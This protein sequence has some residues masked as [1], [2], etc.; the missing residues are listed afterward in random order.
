MVDP[1][2]DQLYVMSIGD[3]LSNV[4][5]AK[6]AP[7]LWRVS[8]LILPGA[9][10]RVRRQ[11][12]ASKLVVDLED[13]NVWLHAVGIVWP[14]APPRPKRIHSRMYRAPKPRQ[15]SKPAR[16]RKES[17][18]RQA[19]QLSVQ[20]PP[21]ELPSFVPRVEG[22]RLGTSSDAPSADRR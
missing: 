22:G 2:L 14:P 6:L 17:A 1:F 7:S 13:V 18:R 10:S 3:H 21:F 9:D 8:A 19:D 11:W 5:K 16:A 20:W 15:E 12:V 4:E